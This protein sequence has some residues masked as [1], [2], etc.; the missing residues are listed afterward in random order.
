MTDTTS[1]RLPMA[2]ALVSVS[3]GLVA[4]AL[5]VL[6]LRTVPLAQSDLTL[7]P[8]AVLP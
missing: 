6:N 1:R 3:L 4:S 8:P 5:L 7:Q 2:L